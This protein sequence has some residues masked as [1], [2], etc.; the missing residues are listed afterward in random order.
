MSKIVID[1]GGPSGRKCPDSSGTRRLEISHTRLHLI[2]RLSL[3]GA[4]FQFPI[5]LFGRYD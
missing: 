2:V 3:R 5:R 4:N 1:V